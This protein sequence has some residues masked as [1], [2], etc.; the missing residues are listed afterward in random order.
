MLRAAPGVRLMRPFR[1]SVSTI[2]WAVGGLTLKYRWRSASAGGLP[3][4]LV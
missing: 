3:S 1:S 2:W 4:T